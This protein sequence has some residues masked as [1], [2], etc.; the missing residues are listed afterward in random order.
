MIIT[1]NINGLN[2]SLKRQSHWMYKKEVSDICC[3]WETYFA[4]K[5]T[6]RLKKWWKKIFSVKE[7][8][9]KSRVAITYFW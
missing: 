2:S 7:I 1:L 4:Y 8:Q 3:L 6:G 9:K 5:N